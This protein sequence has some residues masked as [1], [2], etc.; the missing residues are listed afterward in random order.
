M[1]QAARLTRRI[2]GMLSAREADLQLDAVDDQRASHLVKWPLAVLLRVAIVCVCAGCRSLLE[3]EQLT[4]DMTPQMR[5][6][7][8]LFRRIPDTTWRTVLIGQDPAQIRYV[9]H[10]QIRAAARRKAL[11]PN[12]LPFNV[13]MLDGKSTALPSCDDF[14]AQRQTQDGKFVSALRTM[15][16]SL[17]TTVAQPC[18]DAIATSSAACPCRGSHHS[19]GSASSARYGA[20]RTLCTAP[21]I[22]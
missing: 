18:I 2:V 8:K 4:V 20:W 6:K 19:S 13:A 15:T 9:I 16:V 21:P 1:A 7:L 14:Y 17:V 10:R 3:A 22:R 11:Q 12:N 5:H